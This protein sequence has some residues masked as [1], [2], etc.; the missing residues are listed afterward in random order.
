MER[1]VWTRTVL[2]EVRV[3][4]MTLK[5]LQ[6]A[7]SRG[8]TVNATSLQGK[9]A[10]ASANICSHSSPRRLQPGAS[11][12]ISAAFQ[13]GSSFAAVV[14]EST[15][16]HNRMLSALD[17][18]MEKRMQRCK[19]LD[20]WVGG[21]H[22]KR[23]GQHRRD[24]SQMA[25]DRLSYR[26]QPHNEGKAC[27]EGHENMRQLYGQAL[28]SFHKGP[29]W[30]EHPRLSENHT[31]HVASRR[32]QT[33]RRIEAQGR[34]DAKIQTRELST[35]Y[36]KGRRQRFAEVQQELMEAVKRSRERAVAVY[37][38]NGWNSHPPSQQPSNDPSPCMQRAMQT[39][40]STKGSVALWKR[41]TKVVDSAQ[42]LWKR[43]GKAQPLPPKSIWEFN[44][45]DFVMPQ[46]EP[47]EAP[48]MEAS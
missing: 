4:A 22:R 41:S 26:Q 8:L 3:K 18:E 25:T 35:A 37:T 20:A 42:A 15:I 24:E 12:R 44:A 1:E 40:S 19:G 29:F 46:W 30:P 39:R 31:E 48:T 23:H 7:D 9:P 10:P 43:P 28:S 47:W 34:Q 32:A 16:Y 2:E 38:D 45:E 36:E 5:N 33:F 17:N 21:H 11:P 13:R 6:N 27:I 14:D